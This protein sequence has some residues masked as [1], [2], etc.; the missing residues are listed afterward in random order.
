[1]I[2]IPTRLDY[3]R[4]LNVGNHHTPWPNSVTGGFE[5]SGTYTW[6]TYST[7]FY[8]TAKSEISVILSFLAW[9]LYIVNIRCFIFHIWLRTNQSMAT[10]QSSSA[11]WRQN[12]KRWSNDL[13]PAKSVLAVETL[14]KKGWRC[15]FSATHVSCTQHNA[16][17]G[18]SASAECWVFLGR[19]QIGARL[20][21][22]P[23]RTV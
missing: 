13:R 17:F 14:R 12:L 5:K 22:Q 21:A 18:S 19:C 1:M 6:V 11:R 9:S 23:A 10:W 4:I 16:D 7:Y 8:R 20:T 2:A 3:Q 15:N